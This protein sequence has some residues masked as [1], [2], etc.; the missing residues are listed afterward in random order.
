MGARLWHAPRLEVAKAS[1]TPFMR[2]GIQ[3]AKPEFFTCMATPRLPLPV[4]S[5]AFLGPSARRLPMPFRSPIFRI[6]PRIASLSPK[7]SF[8]PCSFRIPFSPI[9]SAHAMV[10]PTV[11]VSMP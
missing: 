1:A 8:S 4:F 5:A 9:S 3:A 2:R 10:T 11:R 6:S 7:A